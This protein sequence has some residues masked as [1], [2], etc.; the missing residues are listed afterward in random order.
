MAQHNRSA[1][2]SLLASAGVLLLSYIVALLARMAWEPIFLPFAP[3]S[4]ESWKEGTA[5]LVFRAVALNIPSFIALSAVVFVAIR[6][7]NTS[8]PLL[9]VGWLFGV[10]LMVCAGMIDVACLPLPEEFGFNTCGF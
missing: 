10:A 1:I 6:R 2:R 5:F 7:W 8:L 9:I 3:S 4:T